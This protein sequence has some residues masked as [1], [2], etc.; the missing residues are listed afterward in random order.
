MIIISKRFKWFPLNGFPPF[1]EMHLQQGGIKDR[2]LQHFCSRLK[3]TT[4]TV[5]L[6]VASRVSV[7]ASDKHQPLCKLR[8]YYAGNKSPMIPPCPPLASMC[9]PQQ[10]PRTHDMFVRSIGFLTP[11]GDELNTFTASSMTSACWRRSLCGLN[12]SQHDPEVLLSCNSDR[13]IK[14]AQSV[15]WFELS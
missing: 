11:R 9:H 4:A 2:N 10:H 15:C 13:V 12:P 14:E 1:Q 7:S 5:W 6:W 8:V 3:K